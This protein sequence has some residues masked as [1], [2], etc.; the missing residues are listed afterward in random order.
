MADSTNVL[1]EYLISLGFRVDEKGNKKF[2][3]ALNG[4][5]KGATK[6]SKSIVGV[7]IAAQAM[8]TEFAFRMEKLFYASRLAESSALNLQSLSFGGKQAGI[9][10]ITDQVQA[11]ARSI[12]ANPGLVGLLHSL[13]VKVE[14]RDMSDVAKDLVAQLS[15]MP[16]YIAQ[17]YAAMFGIDPDTLKLW[18]DGQKDIEAA[19][20]LAADAAKDVGVNTD[21][22]VKAGKEYAQSWREILLYVGF[23]RDALSIT[24]LGPM[25]DMA[26]A[27]KELLRDWIRIAQA[28]SAPTGITPASAAASG[29][30]VDQQTE[31][32]RRLEEQRKRIA[33]KPPEERTPEERRLS[34]LDPETGKPA[35]PKTYREKT[36]EQRAKDY[37]VIERGLHEVMDP[38]IAGAGGGVDISQESKKRLGLKEGESVAAP[39][40]KG[41]ARRAFEKL[42]KFQKPYEADDASVEAATRPDR[43]QIERERV[44]PADPAAPGLPGLPGEPGAP[45]LPAAAAAPG[46]PGKPGE[47]AAPAPA[48]KAE[49]KAQPKD[50]NRTLLN[51][52]ERKYALPEG[53]LDRVWKRESL[54]GNPKFME[55][56]KGAKGHF[57][58]MDKTAKQYG[59]KDPNDFK[60][61]AEGSAKY[62]ADLLKK[63]GGDIKYAAAAYNW[64][65]GH[66]DKHLQK[67]M[68]SHPNMSMKDLDKYVLGTVPKETRDYVNSVAAGDEKPAAAAGA[69]IHQ[70]TDIHVHGVSDPSA[71]AHEVFEAQRTTNADMVRQLTPRIN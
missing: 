17:R 59:V 38:T 20:K 34:G 29:V 55:S 60:Q 31:I 56:P 4:L 21:E 27:T 42:F 12:R 28:K 65:P 58:F 24:M 19:S 71:A 66:L 23:F 36:P 14:G 25:K 40:S 63:Y 13:G 22:A 69:T 70:K 64:G 54:R 43:V 61:S 5:D 46:L 32:A 44:V 1:R 48:P 30:T 68:D 52:L 9:A 7:G 45:G 3:T 37:N 6:L 26:A 18:I 51:Q 62:F 53:L 41:I 11:L 57:G 16:F 10:N 35:Q 49:A 50:E 47:P 39:E 15:K 2:G 8:V 67:A 33:A